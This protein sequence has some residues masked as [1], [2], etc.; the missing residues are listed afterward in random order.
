MPKL[1]KIWVLQNKSSPSFFVVCKSES[2]KR[3]I[4]NE[5][6]EWDKKHIGII[7]IIAK[8]N[9]VI[10]KLR[11]FFSFS[12]WKLKALERSKEI[13]SLMKRNKELVISRDNIKAKSKKLS[14]KNNE[15]EKRIKELEYELKK[16]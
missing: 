9:M 7:R 16:K 2:Y 1:L 12:N 10:M 3:Q 15:L 8:L 5:Y 11:D 4:V 13:N 14:V 6:N